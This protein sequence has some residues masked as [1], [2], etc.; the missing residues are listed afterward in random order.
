MEPIC[1]H[2]ATLGWT[3]IDV[4]QIVTLLCM[5]PSSTA[6]TAQ[7]APANPLYTLALLQGAQTAM[8]AAQNTEVQK[9]GD[10]DAARDAA[11]SKEWAFHNAV[12]EA[13]KQVGA[14]YG[15]DSDQL[16]SIGLKKKSED[17]KPA[18]KATKKPL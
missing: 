9:K 7:G 15:S 6:N 8:I 11:N 5:A 18:R 4:Q 10:W 3:K 14:Q 1:F 13:K 16:Q 12:L 2:E 17:K